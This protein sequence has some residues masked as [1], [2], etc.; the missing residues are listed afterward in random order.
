MVCQIFDCT[1]AGHFPTTRPNLINNFKLSR[2]R[3]ISHNWCRLH[4][5][6][7]CLKMFLLWFEHVHI[8][9][10]IFYCTLAGHWGTTCLYLLDNF[11]FS[12]SLL[13][14]ATNLT[15]MVHLRFDNVHIICQI[16]YCTYLGHFRTTRLD[17]IDNLEFPRW[18]C[19]V[20]D[21][22]WCHWIRFDGCRCHWLL[23]DWGRLH[24]RRIY[25]WQVCLWFDNVHI[26]CQIFYWTWRG[27]LRT[28]RPDLI[29]NLELPRWHWTLSDWCWCRLNTG[30]RLLEPLLE[31]FNNFHFVLQGLVCEVIRQWVSQGVKLSDDI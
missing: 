20:L 9:R 17:L 25:F 13:H 14:R 5:T 3:W 30:R 1:R 22:C 24:N 6:R 4:C 16:F 27:H 29:N 19:A 7:I 18:H 2:R 8:I 31:L 21:G 28:T 26:I 10:Q 12:R 23:I 15:C 11:L